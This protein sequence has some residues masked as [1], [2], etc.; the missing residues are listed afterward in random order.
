M[1]VT[2]S[3]FTAVFKFTVYYIKGQYLLAGLIQLRNSLILLIVTIK[4]V[5]G[6]NTGN[7]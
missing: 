3:S 2:Q 6:E 1:L 7:L 4:K 5:A